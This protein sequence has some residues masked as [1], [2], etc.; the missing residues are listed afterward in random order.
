[1]EIKIYI[2]IHIYIS[3][4]IYCMLPFQTEKR[5]PKPRQFS[6][7]R[8]P[9]A[10]CANGSLSFVSLFIKKQTE[11]ICL[12]NRLNG[13]N[14]QL[15]EEYFLLVAVYMYILWPVHHTPCACTSYIVLKSARH[16]TPHST[17]TPHTHSIR[18]TLYIHTYDIWM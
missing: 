18:R 7:I 2:Y 14:G 17:L 15:S 3:R 6:L 9:F 8:L 11:D 13:L 5:K 10:H 4:Y 12:L 16:L 1:M